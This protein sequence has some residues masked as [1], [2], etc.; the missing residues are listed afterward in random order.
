MA[1][2]PY[3]S[4]TFDA[5]ISLGAPLSHI[6]EQEMRVRTI[7]EMVRV[8]RPGGCLLITGISQLSIYRA[9]VFGMNE[10]L[11]RQGKAGGIKNHG[12]FDG[13]I[14]GYAF[15]PGELAGLMNE[16]RLQIVD[17]VGCEGLAAHLPADHL[18][19]VEADPELWKVWKEMLLETCNEPSIIGISNHLLVIGRKPVLID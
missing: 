9:I 17:Q 13:W 12:I 14:K 19:Q 15:Q 8:L 6:L 5:V 16:A 4:A 18:E 3:G 7:A 10:S 2:L 11:I 1:A